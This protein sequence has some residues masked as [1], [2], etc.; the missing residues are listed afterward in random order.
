MAAESGLNAV[1]FAEGS[2]G[3]DGGSARGYIRGNDV[4]VRVDHEQFTATQLM[5]HE[6][7]HLLLDEKRVSPEAIIERAARELGNQTLLDLVRCYAKTYESA[8]MTPSGAMLEMICDANG[9]MNIYAGGLESAEAA[10]EAFNAVAREV[11]AEQLEQPPSAEDGAAAPAEM[12]ARESLERLRGDG[13]AYSQESATLEELRKMNRQQEKAIT[14]LQRQ[15]RESRSQTQRW[16][17]E[18]A[19]YPSMR[20]SEAAAMAKQLAA[21]YNSRFAEKSDADELARTLKAIADRML[22]AGTVNDSTE[23]AVLK[24]RAL[25][26]AR[27][28]VHNA[29]ALNEKGGEGFYK[30][31]TADLRGQKIYFPE[32]LRADVTDNWNGFRRGLM[33]RLTLTGS[34]I[35]A[36]SIDTVYQE[37]SESYGDTLFPEEITNPAD[38]LLHIREVL[39]SYRPVYEN[40]YN[41][42]MA[43][44]VEYAAGEV[45]NRI[46]A[47]I[48]EAPGNGGLNDRTY[49]LLREQRAELEEQMAR[50]RERADEA[51]RRAR[52]SR[53]RQVAALNE[54]YRE[55]RAKRLEAQTDRNIRN[56]L[57][58]VAR[59]LSKLKTTKAN[60]ETIK[61]LIGDLDLEARQL[62]GENRDALEHLAAWYYHELDANEDF[63]PD[64]RTKKAINRLMQG[65]I[66]DMTLEEV[67]ALTD[68]LL[69]IE[70][71]IR[72]AKKLIDSEDARDIYAQGVEI[73]E[74][75]KNS[76]GS[77][78][79]GPQA[80]WDKL[81]VTETLSPEREARR[82]TGYNDSDPLY[83]ATKSLSKGARDAYDYEM[84]AN[85]R[86]QKFMEDKKFIR[87]LS[88]K[89]AKTIQIQGIDPTAGAVTVEITKGM[90]MAIYLHGKNSESLRHIAGGGIKVPDMAL[91]RKGSAEAWA[92]GR[93]ITL[94][95]SQVHA[96][97]AGMSLKEKA[98]A[99]AAYDYF[100]GM[101]KDAINEVSEKLK[102]YSLAEVE[103][104]F[105]I[106]TDQNFTKK[107]FEAIKFDGSI[108]GMG[109]L[110]ERINS[111]SPIMLEDMDTVLTRSIKQ[112]AKYYGLAIPVRNFNKLWGVNKNSYDEKTGERNGKESSVQETMQ[113]KWGDSATKYI[114]KMMGDLQSGRTKLS[115]WD[116]ALA[117][118]R[119]N[120]AGS[121]LTF[122]LSVAL[123]QAASYPTAGAVVSYRALTKALGYTLRGGKVDT[124]LIAKYTPLLWYRSL[125][126]S[127]QELGDMAKRGIQLPKALNWIQMVDVA[128]TRTLWKAAEYDV[129]KEAPAL[130]YGTEEFYQRTAEVYNRIIEETQP[131]YTTMQRPQMLRSDSTLLQ[132]LAMFKTQPFQNFNILYDAAGNAMAKARAA[133]VS[134]T[135]ETRAALA[136]ARQDLSRAV[137]S[138]LLSAAV[139]AGM[140]AVWSLFRGRKD[141]YK[142]KD[143]EVTALSLAAGLGKDMIASGAGMLPFGSD[144][145]ELADS[146]ISGS[147]YYGFD[148]VTSSAIDDLA[149]AMKKA[150]TAVTDMIEAEGSGEPINWNDQRLKW[151][152]ILKAVSKV[153]GVPMENVENLFNAAVL[154]VSRRVA[155]EY[156]GTYSYLRLTTSATSSAG[157]GK[158][159]DNLYAAYRN[160]PKAFR[161]LYAMMIESGD[162]NEAAVKAAMENRMKA[163]EGVS[164]VKDLSERFEAP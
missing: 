114:E 152:S 5:G 40:P 145:Y 147:T 96:I 134:D 62:T 68:A 113:Q 100:N 104:Y 67:K 16:R 53:D 110:K 56:R 59:R 164:S 52:E 11:I 153:A 34:S 144:V 8:G 27:L 118:A 92:R 158:Y 103:N 38:Q 163:T 155:G 140:T 71:E 41:Y 150:E 159:Y 73:I 102:G 128:T 47:W 51:V 109:F 14:A 54:H 9:G 30:S 26:A 3:I 108:E 42:D 111:A 64:E 143:G 17:E 132:N 60:R 22:R 28:L 133:K 77:K 142:D 141:K 7:G 87:T 25:K 72:T 44:A 101:S 93:R 97:A 157:K 18:S 86:F 162:F 15:L 160:D 90:R 115:A 12:R 48:G 45:M 91:Y 126:Y 1:F 119:S 131:N 95:P 116:K 21:D 129:M 23:Y 156:L 43:S 123:K 29:E 39:D 10:I 106:N 127:T 55:Q 79:T 85:Q 94:Q 2:L 81:I 107:D 151:D 136:L 88:G 46:A 13:G 31:L 61:A 76:R 57:L 161:E 66:D 112:T 65:H 117:K 130:R 74:D 32:H 138:Q 6:I 98:F 20:A 58:K 49:R 137:T 82:I 37:L 69:N 33:G 148:D 146:I 80:A 63:I 121:V 35:G 105:P 83:R 50:Q 139:F 149:K 75:V 84:R 36:T 125:G 122:N 120:Y 99:D 78:A 19:P 70:N 89:H 154:Q 124:D 4:F 24:E 135:A